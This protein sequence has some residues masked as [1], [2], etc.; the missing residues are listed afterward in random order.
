MIATI[1][2]N[3][4][5][6]S[7]VHLRDDENSPLWIRRNFDPVTR[8]YSLISYDNSCK[9]LSRKGTIIVYVESEDDIS[10]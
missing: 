4:K 9:E 10:F 3:V 7:F 5:K 8:R 1:I 2:Q 6:N